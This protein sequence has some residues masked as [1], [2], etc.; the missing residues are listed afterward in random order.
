[1]K[2]Q[3]GALKILVYIVLIMCQSVWWSL[4]STSMK[5]LMI[6]FSEPVLDCL[7]MYIIKLL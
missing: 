7:C 2:A 6:I 5:F 3:Q 1:M 4:N